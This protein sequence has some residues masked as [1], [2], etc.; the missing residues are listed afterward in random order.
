MS[1]SSINENWLTEF[2][3]TLQEEERSPGTIENYLQ[4]IRTFVKWLNDEN[5]HLDKETAVEWKTHL[6]HTGYRFS[7]V[8]TI[9]AALNK[10]FTFLGR[11]DCHMK[12]LRIQRKLFRSED[13]ELTRDEYQRL[14]AAA[15]KTG[16]QR[17]ALLIE[18]ICATGI[19]VSEVK[20]LTVEAA[21][22]GKADIALKGKIRTIFIPKK[23][24]KKLLAYARKQKS[25]SGEIFRT[26]SGGSLS[27]KQI[28]AEMKL[29][30]GETGIA[31]TKVFPHNLRHLFARCFYKVCRDI[32]K[33]ADI[34]GHSSIETTRIYL[35]STGLEHIRTLD[36]MRL[37]L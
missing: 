30:C 9:L 14:V 27:R 5:R 20:Y 35:I 13:R 36:S 15:Q 4:A 31:S 12:Y 26:R 25:I 32:A 34:L 21:R 24:C 18:S 8:N 23:L 33:L 29:L 19:R 22:C 11:T 10:F 16:Q 2:Q 6:I 1:S 17:L 3:E 7:T 28:W 37:I